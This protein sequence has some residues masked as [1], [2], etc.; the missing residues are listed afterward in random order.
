MHRTFKP[1][2]VTDKA[3]GIDL[4][5]SSLGITSNGDKVSNPKHL[6]KHY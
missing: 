3:I 4:G 5:I 6:K 2:P 1:L